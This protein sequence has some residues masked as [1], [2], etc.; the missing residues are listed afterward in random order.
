MVLLVCL[1][2]LMLP[3]A[4]P[5]A[6]LPQCPPDDMLV[7]VLAQRILMLMLLLVLIWRL[8]EACGD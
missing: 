1:H 6:H 4:V 3:L 5:F 8:H 2:L 7:R